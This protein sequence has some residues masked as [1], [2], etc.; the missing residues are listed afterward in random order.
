MRNLLLLS[1]VKMR[2]YTNYNN[3]KFKQY[4]TY[5]ISLSHSVEVT[6]SSLVLICQHFQKYTNIF[7]MQ[8]NAQLKL[9]AFNRVCTQRH[10]SKSQINKKAKTMLTKQSHVFNNFS[11]LGSSN[12]P[13]NDMIRLQHKKGLELPCIEVILYRHLNHIV[14]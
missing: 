14:S 5:G 8:C 3:K 9:K 4:A 2:K 6:S 1:T 10:C 11:Q 13:I 7:Q 12:Q